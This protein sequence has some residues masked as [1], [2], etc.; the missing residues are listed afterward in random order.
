MATR[1]FPFVSIVDVTGVVT[2]TG[3]DAQQHCLAYSQVVDP[4]SQAPFSPGI[5]TY[6]TTP[7]GT[8]IT[9]LFPANYDSCILGQIYYDGAAQ[10]DDTVFH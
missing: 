3:T 6:V 2:R 7:G 9:T 5:S 10:N 8:P 4:T 1:D